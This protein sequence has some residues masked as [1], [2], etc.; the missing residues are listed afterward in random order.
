MS[1]IRFLQSHLLPALGVA[2]ITSAAVSAAA[3]DDVASATGEK[4]LTSEEKTKALEEDVTQGALRVVK[5]DGAVIYINGEEVRRVGMPAG[6]INHSTFAGRTVGDA[7][8][9][10]PLT[11]PAD[12][13]VEGDNVIAVAETSSAISVDP[14]KSRDIYAAMKPVRLLPSTKGWF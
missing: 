5:D 4:K 1:A 8:F 12:V 14:F 3:A 13:L 2:L 9:E 6:A 11:I 7:T 10:G